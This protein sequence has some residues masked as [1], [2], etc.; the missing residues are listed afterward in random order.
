MGRTEEKG[1]CSKYLN[2]N[3]DFKGLR[4]SSINPFLYIWN[5][6]SDKATRNVG[7]RESS[8][9]H[10][11]KGRGGGGLGGRVEKR[12]TGYIKIKVH[13]PPDPLYYPRPCPT[14]FSQ[15]LLTFTVLSVCHTPSSFDYI[16]L[17]P[18]KDKYKKKGSI[19]SDEMITPI[20]ALMSLRPLL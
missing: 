14:P 19:Q 17:P 2:R 15:L 5:T 8:V 16:H 1:A 6:K 7:Q 10:R 4:V 11:E 12:G 13:P 20:T 9:K 18:N 3:R